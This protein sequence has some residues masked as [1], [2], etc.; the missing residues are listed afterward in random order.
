MSHWEQWLAVAILVMV[1]GTVGN[2][3]EKRLISIREVL[4]RIL[5]QVE[6][7]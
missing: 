3:I 4:G 5:D 6:K 1:I 2:G 7:R